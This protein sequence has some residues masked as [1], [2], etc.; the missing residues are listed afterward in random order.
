M[1]LTSDTHFGARLS[2]CSS[3][4]VPVSSALGN[5]VSS[6]STLAGQGDLLLRGFLLSVNNNLS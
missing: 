1:P 2:K 3:L 6:S 5:G 4:P